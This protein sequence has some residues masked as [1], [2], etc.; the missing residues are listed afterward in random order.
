[1]FTFIC[2]IIWT[3]SNYCI[4]QCSQII[5]F[6]NLL[7]CEIPEIN[8][9]TW[10]TQFGRVSTVV[11]FQKTFQI[12]TQQHMVLLIFK[13]ILMSSNNDLIKHFP[14]KAL[15]GQNGFCSDLNE[16]ISFTLA[17]HISS[18][19]KATIER[20]NSIILFYI[21]S[22]SFFNLS[23]FIYSLCHYVFENF[24]S[25]YLFHCLNQI[26]LKSKCNWFAYV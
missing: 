25:V 16:N 4:E 22:Y 8:C 11:Q 17:F 20:R 14:K 3:Q 23:L 18:F 24:N 15:N 12:A 7:W 6:R 19:N 5:V 21:N 9:F 13:D 2:P 10:R 26:H 1:M